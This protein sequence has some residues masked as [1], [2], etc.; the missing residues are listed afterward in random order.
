[1]TYASRLLMEDRNIDSRFRG[2]DN[3]EDTQAA[4]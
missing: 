3:N 2:N 4:H 1:L